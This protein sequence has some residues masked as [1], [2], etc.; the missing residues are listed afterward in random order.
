MN[1]HHYKDRKIKYPCYIQP[2]LNGIR[3]RYFDGKLYSREGKVWNPEVVE[4]ITKDIKQCLNS[5]PNDIML[6]G[7]LYLHGK[8]LGWHVSNINVNLLKPTEETKLIHFNVFDFH[9]LNDRSVFDFRCQVLIKND[10]LNYLSNVKMVES[11]LCEDKMESD[12]VFKYHLMNNYEGSIYIMKDCVYINGRSHYKLKRKK[13]QQMEV[14]CI[15]TVKGTGKYLNS[16][17][18]LRC[19]TTN[20][21]TVYVGTGFTDKERKKFFESPP[22]DKPITIEYLELS[23]DGVPIN[24]R[25]ISVRDYE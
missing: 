24:P 16:L 23:E 2:K 14:L 9:K 25:F 7:E 18:S 13:V 6:D 3:A 22:F 10:I 15:G 19:L 11:V 21:V 17:G 5:L 4:H 12:A 1:C 20:K 8:P